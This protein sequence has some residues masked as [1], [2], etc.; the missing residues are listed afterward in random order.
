[1]NHLGTVKLETDRLVL[2]PFKIEDAADMFSN[3]AS[4]DEVTRYLTW[5]AHSS[6]DVSKML[7]E[8][9]VKAY[10]APQKYEWCIELKEIGQAIGSIGVVH[11]DENVDAMELGYC[12][13]PAF[14][15]QGITT[16]ALKRV[17][18]F[19]FSE[20]G[21]NRICAYHHTGNTNSGKVMQKAGLTYEGTLKSA[22]KT[23]TGICDMAVY[24]MTKAMFTKQI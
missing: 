18:E 19:L 4:S 17:I 24:G 11:I 10:E 12:V 15:N 20:V 9:W 7:L 1:M 23:N 13:G 2:R 5:P 3:W 21:C 6:V 16:E 22:G 8:S 14:W